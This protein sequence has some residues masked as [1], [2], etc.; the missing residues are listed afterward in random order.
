MVAECWRVLSAHDI[1]DTQERKRKREKQRERESVRTH[2]GRVCD[3]GGDGDDDNNNDDDD[4]DD[5]AVVIGRT[6]GTD[7]RD[8][9]VLSSGSREKHTRHRWR[10]RTNEGEL[11]EK[12]RNARR[13]TGR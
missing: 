12:S 11:K 10:R 1:R 8:T 5:D 7:D 4:G 6:D 9:F 13:R 3:D 2:D